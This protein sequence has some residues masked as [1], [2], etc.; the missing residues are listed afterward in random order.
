MKKQNT[1]VEKTKENY[2]T[3]IQQLQKKKANLQKEECELI[4]RRGLLGKQNESKK[5]NKQIERKQKK[6]SIIEEENS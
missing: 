3:Y 2:Q 5:E 1:K 6:E 4:E